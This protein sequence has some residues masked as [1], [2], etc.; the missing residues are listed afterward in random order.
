MEQNIATLK[1]DTVVE[2]G[3]ILTIL[4]KH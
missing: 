3:I 2:L 4:S 1:V